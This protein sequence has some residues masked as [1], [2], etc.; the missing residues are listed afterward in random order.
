MA[1]DLSSEARWRDDYRGG[2]IADGLGEDPVGRCAAIGQ[3]EGGFLMSIGRVGASAALAAVSTFVSVV[4]MA[5]SAFAETKT[6]S[7]QGC[8]NWAVPAGV[9]QLVV[10]AVGAAGH[11]A[12]GPEPGAGGNVQAKYCKAHCMGICRHLRPHAGRRCLCCYQEGEIMF[13]HFEYLAK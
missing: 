8:S 3:S 6:F 1:Y 9:S 11:A 5:A 13:G 7:E 2:L 12:E 10:T 4:L